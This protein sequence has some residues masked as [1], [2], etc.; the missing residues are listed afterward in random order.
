MEAIDEVCLLLEVRTLLWEVI[1]V[2][3]VEETETAVVRYVL[4]VND[5]FGSV[6]VVEVYSVEEKTVLIDLIGV[7]G[8]SPYFCS[9]CLTQLWKS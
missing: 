5:G 1:D 3:R 7:G 2:S 4:V 8:A 6:A 9:L